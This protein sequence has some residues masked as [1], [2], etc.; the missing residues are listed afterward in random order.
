M[1]VAERE[2]ELS[3]KLLEHALIKKRRETKASPDHSNQCS[4]CTVEHV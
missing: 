4:T 1:N 3:E 2:Q